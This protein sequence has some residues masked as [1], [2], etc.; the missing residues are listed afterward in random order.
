MNNRNILCIF[1]VWNTNSSNNCERI[2]PNYCY[3][4][5][6]KACDN[7]QNVPIR[8]QKKLCYS[9]SAFLWLV[10]IPGDPEP[11]NERETLFSVVLAS[12]GIVVFLS[13]RST[14][15]VWPAAGWA[16]SR[17]GGGNQTGVHHNQQWSR[18]LFGAVEIPYIIYRYILIT[19]NMSE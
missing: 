9:Y 7:L 1:G 14:V 11:K 18:S 12:A 3:S 5:F 19:L 8:E 15:T 4:L 16:M 2:R 13:P 17:A 10:E 6:A